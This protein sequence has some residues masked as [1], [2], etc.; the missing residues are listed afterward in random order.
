MPDQ[1]NPVGANLTLIHSQAELADRGVMT[2]ASRPLQGQSPYV[3]NVDL[4]WSSPRTG[5]EVSALYNVFGRRI[6]E[7]GIEGLPDVYEQPFHRVDLA[8]SQ[9]LGRGFRLKLAGTNLL[10]QPVVIRQGDLTVQRTAPGVTGSLSLE[11]SR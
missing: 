1:P 5:T 9:T 11:W 6:S 8:A 2:S 10:D 7:V 4:G 3:V